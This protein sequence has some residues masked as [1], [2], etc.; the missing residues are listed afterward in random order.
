MDFLTQLRIALR[1]QELQS[2][3]FDVDIDGTDKLQGLRC[4]VQDTR[5]VDRAFAGLERGALACHIA[6]YGPGVE[7]DGKPITDSKPRDDLQARIYGPHAEQFSSREMFSPDTLSQTIE[8][9]VVGPARLFSDDEELNLTTSG[10]EFRRIFTLVRGPGDKQPSSSTATRQ[11]MA[12][13]VAIS[14]EDEELVFDEDGKRILPVIHSRGIS[15]LE[16]M[17]RKGFDLRFVRC[18]AEG[19]DERPAKNILMQFIRQIV[20][21]LIDAENGRFGLLTASPYY[22]LVEL[23]KVDGKMH[24]LVDR[25]YSAVDEGP[26]STSTALYR[27]GLAL[28]LSLFM[29][30]K[31]DFEIDEPSED[32]KDKIRQ[33]MRDLGTYDFK[34]FSPKFA[35]L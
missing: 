18:L 3:D 27:P 7:A 34:G 4:A 35:S 6:R 25:P 2:P 5:I 26:D 16:R 1:I 12:T 28:L 8:W 9:G 31:S 21:R 29:N 32:I 19:V 23:V 14:V 30:H 20:I 10:P 24:L 22:M 17:S 33:K 13:I 11:N 15:T